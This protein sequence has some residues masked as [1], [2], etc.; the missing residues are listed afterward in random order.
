M[1]PPL[2][3]KIAEKGPSR[4]AQ[5]QKKTEKTQ[6]N[7]DF[8]TDD[9][10]NRIF[11]DFWS[12]PDPLGKGKTM[13]NHC[14]VIKNQG[15]AL[16]EKMT[17]RD[18][19][20]YHFG[21]LLGAF[22]TTFLIFRLFFRIQKTGEKSKGSQTGFGRKSGEPPHLKPPLFNPRGGKREG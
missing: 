7:S 21:T 6:T 19:F 18:R 5:N 8:F 12:L 16:V 9:L 20:W 11:I 22:W 2:V 15:F 3:P 10:R 17:L 1:P 14:T 13:K 4:E